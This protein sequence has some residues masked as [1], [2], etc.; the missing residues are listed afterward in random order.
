MNIKEKIKNRINAISDP[1]LLDE[2]LKAVELEYEIEHV[3]E[4]S[5]LEKK[6]IDNGI[7]DAEA[8][9]LYSNAEASQLVKKW[10]KK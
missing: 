4:L 1:R 3:N 6:A 7:S 2:I 9:N 5:E 10:L 8:G